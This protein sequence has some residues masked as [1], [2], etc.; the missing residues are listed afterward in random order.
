MLKKYKNSEVIN[1]MKWHSL[2]FDLADRYIIE[3]ICGLKMK[4]YIVQNQMCICTLQKSEVYAWWNELAKCF[5]SCHIFGIYPH[6]SKTGVLFFKRNFWVGFNSKYP[7]KSGLLN[8]KVG[9]YWVCALWAV[10]RWD[11]LTAH[12][13]FYPRVKCTMSGRKKS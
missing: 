3:G 6:Q 1:K 8:K 4:T 13:A 5:K 12:S 11:P 2:T 7:S 9:L 10:E